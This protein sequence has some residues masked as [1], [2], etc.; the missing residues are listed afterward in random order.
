MTMKDY[1]SWADITASSVSACSKRFIS[2]R[3]DAHRDFGQ[4]VSRHEKLVSEPTLWHGQKQTD[5]CALAHRR[6][7]LKYPDTMFRICAACEL[8]VSARC[9]SELS[10]DVASGG[11][12][13]EAKPR[14]V[15]SWRRKTKGK[16]WCRAIELV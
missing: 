16:Q 11:G 12:D 15:T 6:R 9:V 5:I 4:T 2:V 3:G 13:N 8:I 1:V 10:K 14:Q 7:S